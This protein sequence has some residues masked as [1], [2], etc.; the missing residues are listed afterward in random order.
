M[1]MVI[2]IRNDLNMRKGKMIAQ[3]SHASDSAISNSRDIDLEE[4]RDYHFSKKIVVSVNSEEELLALFEKASNQR[5]LNMSKLIID[6]GFTEFKGV[7][8]PTAFAIGPNI[9]EN[10][11]KIS[12][13]L[14]LL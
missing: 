7:K 9:D 11:D 4:W 12:K 5:N 14:K 10:V 2:L 6:E 3:G 1:K 8:T 13:K